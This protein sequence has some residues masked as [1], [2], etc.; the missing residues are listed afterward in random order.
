ASLVQLGRAPDLLRAA[1]K[2][3]PGK[4]GK[5]EL[6]HIE[7]KYL[8]GGI[9]FSKPVR[10]VNVPAG[11]PFVQFQI[12][13]APVGNYF[14]P[15]GTAGNT[16]GFYTGGRQQTVHIFNHDVRALQSTAKSITDTWSVPGWSISAPGGGTQ[17]FVP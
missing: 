12:P 6:H 9:D 4:A 8:G 10:M 3:F 15:V 5:I 13:G 16:L 17:L 14:A 1:Q 11:T 2:E 7:P